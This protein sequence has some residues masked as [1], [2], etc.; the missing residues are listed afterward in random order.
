MTDIVIT[1]AKRTAIG[2][3]NGT[4]STVPAH[5]LGAHVIEAVLQDSKLNGA[6]VDQVILGQVLTAA[7]GQNPARQ[8]A[9]LAGI[10]HDK[11]ALTINQVCG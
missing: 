4:L 8:A 9:V 7:Q 2:T 6:D 1:A 3:F 5:Q 11:T 10:P